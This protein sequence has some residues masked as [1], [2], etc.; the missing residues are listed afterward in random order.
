MLKDY[1]DELFA[2]NLWDQKIGISLK[3]LKFIL[4]TIQFLHLILLLVN[5][6]KIMSLVVLSSLG[7]V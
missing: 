7:I 5:G 6:V 3:M 4:M 1:A 2:L